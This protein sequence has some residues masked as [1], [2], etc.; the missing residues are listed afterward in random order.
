MEETEQ[1]GLSEKLVLNLISGTTKVT[2][3]S[4]IEKPK[5]KRSY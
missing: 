2:S 1:V 5:K 3:K 4:K